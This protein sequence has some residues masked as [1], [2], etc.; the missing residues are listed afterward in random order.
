MAKN[1]PLD[2]DWN[3][4]QIQFI[5]Y[6]LKIENRPTVAYE[7]IGI[8]SWSITLLYAYLVLGAIQLQI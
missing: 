4:L 7:H 1:F 6:L 3:L 2:Y 8:A 5:Y